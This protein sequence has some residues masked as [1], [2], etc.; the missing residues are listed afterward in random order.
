MFDRN[1][2]RVILTK[3]GEWLNQE[4]GEILTRLERIESIMHNVS[5]DPSGCVLRIGD[6]GGGATAEI[7]A[8][9]LQILRKRYPKKFPHAN[10]PWLSW[11]AGREL[12]R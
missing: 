10:G 2:R 11:P 7:L 3:A 4:L 8:P 12:P 5:E 1:N 9:A 6:A